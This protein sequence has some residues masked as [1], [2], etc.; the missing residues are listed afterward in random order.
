MAPNPV[1]QA[2]A[3]TALLVAAWLTFKCPCN[4]LVSCHYKEVFSLMAVATTVILHE[5]RLNIPLL[6]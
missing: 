4:K 3:A 2:V 1:S 6:D 5:N